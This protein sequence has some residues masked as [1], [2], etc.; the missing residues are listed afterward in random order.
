MADTPT[1]A[2][3]RRQRLWQ[4]LLAAPC[5]HDLLQ[6]LR[7][8]QALE[9]DAPRLGEALRPRDE[10]VRL[11][12]DAELDFAAANV[13]SVRTDRP[14]PRIGQRAF[15]LFGPMGPMPLHLSEYLRERERQ[16]ND[17]TLA[18]FADLFH[19][20]AL[21]LFFRA[22]AQ[23]RPEVHHDRPWDD[24]FARWLSSLFGQGGPAFAQRS[25]VA[26]NAKRLHAAWLMRGPRN[27][28][29]LAAVIRQYFGLPVR[30]E[31]CV[32]HWL[33]LDEQ[34]RTQLRRASAPPRNTALGQNAVLGQRVWDRQS[35]ARLHL[36]PLSLSQ[37][38][39]LQADEPT[40]LALRDW[41]REY[42]G[43]TVAVDLLLILR[44]D[45]VPALRLRRPHAAGGEGSR[46]G[47]NTWLG[48]RGPRRDSPRLHQR[49]TGPGSS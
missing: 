34:D 46:L 8:I 20:R 9:S 25:R 31:V 38:L 4:Q 11:G 27:A 29:G 19:H 6:T 22:W 49:L 33:D 10:A 5:A 41:V 48:Q 28:E 18:R 7:R 1:P 14:V 40:W 45:E 13:H 32:G 23:S 42:L 37:F 47:R 16:H 43:L 2:D 44:P 26:D 12:Q 15:G 30:V 24:D 39:S 21:L 35:L 17:P 36:G 3:P